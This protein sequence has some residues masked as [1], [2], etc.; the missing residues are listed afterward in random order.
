MSS[1]LRIAALGVM[2]AVV[3]YPLVGAAQAPPSLMGTWKQNIAAS[4][5]DP[6]PLPKS[7]TSHWEAVPGGGGKNATDAVDAG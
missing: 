6:G 7:Q 1:R 3:A 4:K 2:L 5:A